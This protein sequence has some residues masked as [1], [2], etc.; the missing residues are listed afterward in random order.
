MKAS[1]FPLLPVYALPGAQAIR[2][3]GDVDLTMSML[4]M[5]LNMGLSAAFMR[6]YGTAKS[7]AA[8]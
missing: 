4:G 2:H 5:F 1:G 7:D 6:Y 3:L 8:R